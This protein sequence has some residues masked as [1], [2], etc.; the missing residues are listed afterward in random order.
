[1]TD[2]TATAECFLPYV[3][4]EFI[5]QKNHVIT[6]SASS[7]DVGPPPNEIYRNSKLIWLFL[8]LL[9]NRIPVGHIFLFIISYA[10]S[11]TGPKQDGQVGG[12][13]ELRFDACL[14][15]MPLISYTR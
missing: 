4:L 8:S 12:Q 10:E 13:A 5:I 9:I 11:G 1:V 7:S 15:R 14:N 3:S 2:N 6:T